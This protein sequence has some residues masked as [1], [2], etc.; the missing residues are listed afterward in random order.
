MNESVREWGTDSFMSFL[1]PLT[2]V[3][4]WSVDGTPTKASCGNGTSSHEA[5]DA[6]CECGL[7][8]YHPWSGMGQ[9]LVEDSGHR[10]GAVV[11][12]VEAWGRVE[13]HSEGFRAEYA[14]PVAFF[15]ATSDSW[16]DHFTQ[17]YIRVLRKLASGCGAEIIDTRRRGAIGAWLE[18]HPGQLDPDAVRRLLP[19]VQVGPVRIRPRHHALDLIG[20][21]IERLIK[22]IG[23]LLYGIFMT[24][25]ISVQLI[26][27]GFLLY[28][29]FAAVTGLDPLGI[30]SH[31]GPDISDPTH[32]QQDSPTMTPG[33]L[34]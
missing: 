7:Y 20:T 6:D 11:G 9:H 19:G 31:L 21:G 22:G 28:V 5:P 32:P 24:V 3:E 18:N 13:V 27:W 17:G 34:R 25:S 23:I 16:D 33:Q 14:K 29:I 2:R 1:R 12:L 10:D 15:L 30:G 26:W 4:S 8:A